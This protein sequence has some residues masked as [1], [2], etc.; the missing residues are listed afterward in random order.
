MQFITLDMK[1]IRH[2]SHMRIDFHEGL[3]IVYGPNES[4]KSTVLES[5]AAAVLRPTM[6]ESASMKQWDAPSSEVKLTYT[7]DSEPFTITR[8]FHPVER[9]LL[10]GEGVFVETSEEIHALM[11]DHSG[12]AERRLLENSTVVK[13]NEMQILQEEGSRTLISDRIRTHLSGVP[14]RSTDEALEFLEASITE[15]AS[16]LMESEE[17]VRSK[18][19]ELK[20]FK[21]CEEELSDLEQR[22]AVYKGDLQRDQSLLSGYEILLDFREKDAECKTFTK[23]QEEVENL[24]AYIRKLPIREREL[25]QSLQEELERISSHQDT[26]ITEKRKT[27]DELSEEKARLSSIDDE[28]EREGAEKLGLLSKLGSLFR[29]SARTRK[30]ELAAKRVEIS[31]NMA[32]MEDLLERYDEEISVWRK[33]FQEKGEKLQHFLD[34]CGEYENWTVDML[35]ARKKEYESRIEEILNG[36]TRGELEEK[37]AL[38]RCEADDLRAALVK[39]HP[40]LK[41]RED[42]E[43]IS[44]E[45]EKL[46]EIIEEW[47]EKIAGLKAQIELLSSQ[48]ER[49]KVAAATLH[50]LK[51][52][53]EERELQMKADEIARDVITLVYQKVKEQFAPELEERAQALLARITQGR[54]QKISVRK[55]DLR[56]LV[57]TPEKSGPVDVDVLSQGTRDQVYLSVRIALSELLSGDRS[58][59]LLFDEAFSTFDEDRLKETLVILKEIAETT[60][61]IVFTHDTSYAQYGHPIPLKKRG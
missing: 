33:K 27:R 50:K 47:K 38:M 40:D 23:I 16:F 60:Q 18:E 2:F 49:R 15:T 22:I 4:G 59:P 48:A 8:I 6:Q 31:Q 36:M 58:P 11:E 57:K 41:E 56:I 46:A 19:Q 25:V 1:G 21:G 28:L 10:E 13:Q 45:K 61:V 32:R 14:D 51:K 53:R 43:R 54:Y 37:I 7:V 17:Q 35:E 34:Q 55:E 20:Q 12:F 52:E 9:D 5:L 44:I 39:E 42:V 3:N 26:L 30:E 24:E 29:K